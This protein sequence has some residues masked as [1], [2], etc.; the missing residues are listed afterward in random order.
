MKVRKN[1]PGL[2]CLKA[3]NLTWQK[4][5]DTGISYPKNAKLKASMHVSDPEKK[6]RHKHGSLPKTTARRKNRGTMQRFIPMA[7]FGFY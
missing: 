4:N 7:V 2:Q 1:G 6:F 5:V 3:D